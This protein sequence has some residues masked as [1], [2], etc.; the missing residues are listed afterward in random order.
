[1]NVL[2]AVS[3]LVVSVAPLDVPGCK[4]SKKEVGSVHAVTSFDVTMTPPKTKLKQ[5]LDC[6]GKAV[7]LFI[8]EYTAAAKRDEASN[9]TGPQLW[10]GDGPSEEHDDELLFKDAVQV[11]VSGPGV[12]VAADALVGKGFKA[13]R[14][15]PAPVDVLSRVGKA[16]DCGADSKD[17]LR[18]WCAAT[19]T[20]KAGF[21]AQ[22][23][24]TVLLGIS[25]P[26]P[27]KLDVRAVM[28]KA[29]R[30]SALSFG[31]G[32]VVLTDVTPDN[33]GEARELA[34]VAAQVASA[35]KGQATEV[36]TS[37]G[38]AGF[39]PTLA[40]KAANSGAAVKDSVK[41]PAQLA[42]KNPTRAWTVKQGKG[43]V[44]VIAE[45]TADG[46]WLSV[47]PVVPLTK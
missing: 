6:G 13:W 12:A 36:K 44:Y 47:Y 41:G 5:S 23:D 10:G 8:T 2:L 31:G 7:T 21:T 1:L 17:P 16:L 15:G 42:L 25:V 32:K 14:G 3:M 35:L 26:L 22:K 27:A 9:M 40:T 45:D 24:K 33:D 39:L 43:E 18:A 34:E 30:V 20:G 46:A 37:A 38:L 29:L 28:L 11:V 4:A 19:M